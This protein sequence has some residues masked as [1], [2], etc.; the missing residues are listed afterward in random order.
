[1]RKKKISS[2][3]RKE[4][5]ERAKNRCEYCRTDSEISES[6]F[7]VE[8]IIPEV[9]GGATLL[10]NL[11]LSCHGCNLHK[12]R[13]INNID[14]L[15]GKIERLFDPRK[16]QWNKHFTWTDDYTILV[17]IT[18]TGRVTV[19]TLKMN[20]SGLVRKRRVLGRSGEHPPE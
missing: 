1:M 7:D 6:P 8:H 12:S 13:R 19:D 2:R 10:E 16:D 11:A 9:E 20:R 18:P 4:V 3:L 14:P 17:G 15:S 5:Y